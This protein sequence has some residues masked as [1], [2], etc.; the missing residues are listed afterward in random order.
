[1][2]LV[3]L[4][5]KAFELIKALELGKAQLDVVLKKIEELEKPK[6]E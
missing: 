4:K 2:E 3:E 1:M 6:S 5:A